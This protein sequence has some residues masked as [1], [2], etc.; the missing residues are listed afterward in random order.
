MTASFREPGRKNKSKKISL[1]CVVFVRNRPRPLEIIFLRTRKKVDGHRGQGG[2]GELGPAE[3]TTAQVTSVAHG[4]LEAPKGA[5]GETQGKGPQARHRLPFVPGASPGVRLHEA[6]PQS[7]AP[8]GGPGQ[9]WGS[10]RRTGGGV[11]LGPAGDLCPMA[12]ITKTKPPSC[13]GEEI[14]GWV[15]GGLNKGDHPPSFPNHRWKGHCKSPK[16]IRK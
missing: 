16:I 2:R 12:L 14:T 10:G 15:P 13:Q 3:V 6:S 1:L 7:P 4:V 11:S 9:P 8:R 5:T